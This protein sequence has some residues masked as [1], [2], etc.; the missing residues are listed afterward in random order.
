MQQVLCVVV[1]QKSLITVETRLGFS[2]VLFGCATYFVIWLGSYAAVRLSTRM[3]LL[4]VQ[5]SA[6]YLRSTVL[7]RPFPAPSSFCV[8]IFTRLHEVLWASPLGRCPRRR[9]VHVLSVCTAI[10][11]LPVRLADPCN[12]CLGGMRFIKCRCD[13]SGSA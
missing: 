4:T 8:P 5:M 9:P 12:S 13:R 11:E 3:I 10:A 1:H 7:V 2:S 6:L